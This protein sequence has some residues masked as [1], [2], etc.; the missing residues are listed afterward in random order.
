MNEAPIRYHPGQRCPHTAQWRIFTPTGE[1]TLAE[2][3]VDESEPFPPIPHGYTYGEPDT[4]SGGR[5]DAPPVTAE[6]D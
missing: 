4:S 5:A 3:Q 1:P 6:G 2:R